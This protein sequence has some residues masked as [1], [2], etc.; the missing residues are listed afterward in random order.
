MFIRGSRYRSLRE[1]TLLNSKGE[2]IRGKDVRLIPPLETVLAPTGQQVAHTVLEADRL[3]LLSF[4]YYGD[5]T[6]WW[7]IGDANPEHPFPNDLLDQRPF[8]EE[9]FILL[10]SGF[11]ERYAQLVAVLEGLATVRPNQ[12]NYF[13]S[14]ETQEPSFVEASV[15]VFHPTVP[16]IRQSIILEIQDQGFNF[17]RSFAWEEGPNTTEAFTF[18]DLKAKSDWRE[19]ID[20]LAATPGV[21]RVDPNMTDGVQRLV[22]NGALVRRESISSLIALKGFAEQAVALSRLGEKIRVPP[23]EVLPSTGNGG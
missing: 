13:D 8:V 3:D 11:Q 19:L 12:I 21:S 22:Y 5:T 6:K 7:Q 10:H 20:E 17:L 15:V 23:N 9:Q 2:W 4:K 14:V 18:E 1:T 16:T